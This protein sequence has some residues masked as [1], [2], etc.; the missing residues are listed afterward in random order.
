MPVAKLAERCPRKLLILGGL[1]CYAGFPLVL[2]HAT[3][4]GWIVLAFGLAGL[5][6]FGEPA[7]KALI[8]DLAS[9]EIRGRVVGMY[10][11]ILGLVVFPASLLGGW[12]WRLDPQ[13]P[14]YAA[15]GFGS[16]GFLVYLIWGGSLM[17]PTSRQKSI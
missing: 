11:L 13:W 17:V 16:T 15:C 7:R 3:T 4:P 12:L 8:V 9:L 2:A 6:E 10:Y 1:A 14:F 5:R